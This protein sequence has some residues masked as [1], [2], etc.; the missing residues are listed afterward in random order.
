MEVEV[1]TFRAT[2]PGNPVPKERPRFNGH[3]YTPKRTRDAEDWIRAHTK[4]LPFLTGK[5]VLSLAFFR[6][7][8]VPCDIDNLTKLVQD[9][10]NGRAWND[11]RQIVTLIASKDID[12]ANPRTEIEIREVS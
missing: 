3:A 4:R 2:V 10:L 8:A 6:K 5:V 11:D 12:R 1:S 7:D 9:A